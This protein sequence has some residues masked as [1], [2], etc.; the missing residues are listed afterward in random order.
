LH[1]PAGA[2]AR[3]RRRFVGRAAEQISHFAASSP[4]TSAPGRW[5]EAELRTIELR[6]AL[7]GL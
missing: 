2:L 4:M 7:E 3:A 1:Q 6:I 5:R